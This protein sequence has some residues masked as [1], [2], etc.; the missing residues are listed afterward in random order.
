MPKSNVIDIRQ[1][2]SSIPDFNNLILEAVEAIAAD[3]GVDLVTI[4][5]ETMTPAEKKY[6][7]LH[8]VVIDVILEKK[9]Q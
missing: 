8:R 1:G 9:L 6:K 4:V 2:E 5:Q 3:C 7:G